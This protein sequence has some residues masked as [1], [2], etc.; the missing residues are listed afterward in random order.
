MLLPKV[1]LFDLIP[2][3][4][5]SFHYLDY[6]DCYKI[7]LKISTSITDYTIKCEDSIVD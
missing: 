2:L 1:L 7:Q 6:S 5:C 4:V 3:N